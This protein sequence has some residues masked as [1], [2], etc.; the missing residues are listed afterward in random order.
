MKKYRAYIIWGKINQAGAP[1]IKL[2]A[3]STIKAAKSFIRRNDAIYREM[4]V[5]EVIA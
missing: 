1:L 2:T 3:C 4:Q 5:R